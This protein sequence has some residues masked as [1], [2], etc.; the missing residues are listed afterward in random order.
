[1]E[2]NSTIPEELLH[3][4]A[5]PDCG[6]DLTECS[7]DLNDRGK[8]F[9][10]TGAGAGSCG[11]GLRCAGCGGRFEVRDG[12]PI[13]YPKNFDRTHIEEEEKLGELMKR[14][15]TSGAAL[16]SENQWKESKKEFWTHVQD[17]IGADLHRTVVYIGCGID[18]RFLRLQ[19][20]GH[21]VVAFDLTYHL[22]D[23]LRADHGSRFNV[24]G[25]VQSLPFKRESFDCLCCIDLIHHE[26]E[27]V[28]R[29]LDSFKSIL[30]P[31][32]LLFLEDTNA[33]GLYQFP[34]S[35]LLPKRLHGALRSFYHRLKRSTHRPADYEFPTSVWGTRKILAKLGFKD[36]T[37]VSQGAYPNIRPIGYKLYRILSRSERVRKYHNFHY[38]IAARK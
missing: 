34:K 38:M 22:L 13:L 25:A 19:E 16:F 17:A 26:Y 7:G 3:F 23:T 33:W 9:Q 15:G 11:G 29:I 24:A 27:A 8:D 36:I 14:P 6:G 21:T 1:M 37:V 18:T 32:G 28:P 5:C 4:L 12:I 10:G 30:K 20:L 31:G 35:I 2:T